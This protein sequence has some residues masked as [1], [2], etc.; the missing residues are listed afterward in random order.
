VKRLGEELASLG[1][2]RPTPPKQRAGGA[3][4][5]NLDGIKAAIADYAD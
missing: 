4:Y 2:P 1:V 3:A 5:P